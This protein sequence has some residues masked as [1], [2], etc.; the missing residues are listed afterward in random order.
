MAGFSNVLDGGKTSQEYDFVM[1]VLT[2]SNQV[3]PMSAN[4]IF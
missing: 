2:K 1:S 4:G 3:N